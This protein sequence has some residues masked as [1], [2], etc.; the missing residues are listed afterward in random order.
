MRKENLLKFLQT[1]PEICTSKLEWYPDDSGVSI[2]RY[3][4]KLLRKRSLS[5]SVFIQENLI[6]IIY[7]ALLSTN[8]PQIQKHEKLSKIQPTHILGT[9]TWRFA[10]ILTK[11]DVLCCA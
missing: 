1:V 6:H 3:L 8:I 11:Q 5:S 2:S 10:I 7:L 9:K 4:W